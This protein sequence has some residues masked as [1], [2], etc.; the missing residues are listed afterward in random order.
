MPVSK[1]RIQPLPSGAIAYPLIE[2]GS[3]HSSYVRNV[4]VMIHSRNWRTLLAQHFD[5]R[6]NP[7]GINRKRYGTPYHRQST[8]EFQIPCRAVIGAHRS[9]KGKHPYLDLS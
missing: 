9:S 1:H 3:N 8:R 2:S 5:T 6:V 4:G 7:P